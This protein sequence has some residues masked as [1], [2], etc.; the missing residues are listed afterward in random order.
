MPAPIVGPIVIAAAT[1]AVG[2]F[3]Q[4]QSAKIANER[5]LRDA[6]LALARE[7]FNEVCTSIG[8]VHYFLRSAATPGCLALESDASEKARPGVETWGQYDQAM[9]Q[10]ATHWNRHKAQVRKYFGEES[11]ALFTEIGEEFETAREAIEASKNYRSARSWTRSANG[12]RREILQEMKKPLEVLDQKIEDLV[13]GMMT[14][15]QE[16]TVGALGKKPA[17][18]GQK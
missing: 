3:F 9:I 17:E 15:I 14:K 2:H 18:S 16:Q 5:Q 4:S 8:R 6:E 12:G 13:E 11:H 7:I 1:A 10:W